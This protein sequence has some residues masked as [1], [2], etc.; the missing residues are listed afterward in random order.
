MIGYMAVAKKIFNNF[1]LV[2]Q[3]NHKFW[4][5]RDE[6]INLYIFTAFTLVF[7]TKVKFG[8]DYC[9]WRQIYFLYPLIIII[10][11]VGLTKIN[12]LFNNK[13]I[14]QFLYL[15]I[16]L[17]L[18]FLSTWNYKNHPYQFVYFNPIFKSLTKDKFD[19]DYWGISN[20]SILEKIYNL[21]N[22]DNIKITTI[23]YT[24][25]N[26]SLRILDPEIR[27]K[28]SIVYDLR[29]ADFVI[30]NHIKKWNTTPGEETLKRNFSIVYNLI[31]D[32][33]II[34]TVYKRN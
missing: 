25:L 11:L 1:M 22:K 27:N 2:E 15:V 6:L 32:G 17:E 24:N 23:S 20:R 7:L 13:F 33:N 8:V 18:I 29:E 30:D 16:F 14:K 28:I 3:K 9:G 31:I 34:N 21:S 5:N 26:D 10:G 19:L 4:F 12:K